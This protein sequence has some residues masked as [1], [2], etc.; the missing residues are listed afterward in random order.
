MGCLSLCHT[1]ASESADSL[2]RGVFSSGSK[3]S[4]L[5]E[6]ADVGGPW[7]MTLSNADGSAVLP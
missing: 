6:E 7:T 4:F 1:L 3:S 2:D 5:P